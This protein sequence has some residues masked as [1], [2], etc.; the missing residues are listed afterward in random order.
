MKTDITMTGFARTVIIDAKYYHETLVASR[1]NALPK[2]ISKHLY[3]LHTYLSIWENDHPNGPHPE[4]ILLYPTV[5]D[6]VELNLKIHGY[7]IRV[8]TVNL[9]Q[10]WSKIGKELTGIIRPFKNVN[11]NG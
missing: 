5:Q 1:Q 10:P 2:I 4:G 9:D 7:P 3:Q 6:H 11:F 8:V